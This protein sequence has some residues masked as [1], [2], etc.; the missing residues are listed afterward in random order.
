MEEAAA[1]AAGGSMGGGAGSPSMSAASISSPSSP[2]HAARALAALSS[3]TSNQH[4]SA[5]SICPIE[6]VDLFIDDFF[7]YVH[8]L[9]PF[10]HEPSIREAW[11]RREDLSS[12]SFLALLAS[13]IA[14]LVASFPRKPRQHLK[15]LKKEHLFP[16]HMSLINRC[17]KICASARGPGYLENEDLGVN[18]AAASYFLAMVGMYTYRWRQARL[19]FGESLTIVRTLGIHKANNTTATQSN[20]RQGPAV[21]FDQP[22]DVRGE[23]GADCITMEMGRRINWALFV[24]V[25]SCSQLGAEFRELVMPPPTTSEGYPPFPA[26]ADD[27]CIHPT[28]ID[29]QPEALLSTITGFIANVR[30]FASYH[31]LTTMEMAW[32]INSVVDW[33]RQRR[34]LFESLRRCKDAA[35]EL[36]PQLLINTSQHPTQGVFP[37]FGAGGDHTGFDSASLMDVDQTPEQR[38]QM[39]YE[40]QKANIYAS[41]LATRSYIV[42]KYWNLCEARDRSL[43]A[44]RQNSP[45]TGI[46]QA[47]LDNL[48]PQAPT[49]HY[50]AIEHEM[51][52]ERE[53]IMKDLLVVLTTIKEVHMEPNADSFVSRPP[54]PPCKIT[55]NILHRR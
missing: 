5:E 26:E 27:F 43:S 39:Q 40:I 35:A 48:L 25:K 8:P 50:D 28:H 23:Q 51:K 19:Y 47:G 18:D 9:C 13:M 7:T 34:V 24:S 3:H 15:M 36:P 12:N 22:S 11:R 10:P 29:P 45:G 4:L 55:A 6:L 46:T 42:Q 14:M 53:S 44:S 52:Q 1:A 16:N 31:S 41:C 30:V 2:T 17:Q 21:S 49:S 33:E 54:P 38:R 37:N 32:G 20:G